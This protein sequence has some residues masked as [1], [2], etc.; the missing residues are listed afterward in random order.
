MKMRP[1]K[2]ALSLF[3]LACTALPAGAQP[4]FKDLVVRLRLDQAR[5]L[6]GEPAWAE[7]RL[8]NPDSVLLMAWLSPGLAAVAGI[9]VFSSDGAGGKEIAT[10]CW[11]SRINT[12]ITLA[13]P[14]RK[15]GFLSR[16][17][18][19]RCFGDEKERVFLPGRYG[20]RARFTTLSG[21]QAVS[22]S[23]S[24]EV[25]APE[26]PEKEL[27]EEILRTRDRDSRLEKLCRKNPQSAY[28][29]LLAMRY[30]GGATAKGGRKTL[31]RGIE[32]CKDLIARGPDRVSSAVLVD[33]LAA[34][35]GR[36]AGEGTVRKNLEGVV[37]RHP[38]TAASEAAGAAL[39]RLGDGK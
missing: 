17:E 8:S 16:L 5:Y 22:D 29:P 33:S 10:H 15:T 9:Q 4:G 12:P 18:L 39:S 14:P 3:L 25:A 26:G 34:L 27:Y 31:Q 35:S 13:V 2:T 11:D 23:A 36:L 24:F 38:G 21:D 20:L 19:S 32:L 1:V 6:A 30:F 37:S 28:A 7:V